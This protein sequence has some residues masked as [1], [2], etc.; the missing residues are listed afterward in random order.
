MRRG[1]GRRTGSSNPFSRFLRGRLRQPAGRA[2]A[3]V[4]V[5]DRLELLVI[6]VY[7]AGEAG[8]EDERELRAIRDW[9]EARYARYEAELAPHWRQVRAGGEVVAGDPLRALWERASAASLVRDWRA[10]QL[11]P[12]ARETINR[13]LVALGEPGGEQG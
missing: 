9:M 12:A 7:R 13:W 3:L 5:W 8:P 4:E 11:L 10:M 1:G 6:A 2:E